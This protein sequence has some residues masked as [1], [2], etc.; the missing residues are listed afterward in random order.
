MSM[1][2]IDKTK[3]DELMQKMK[4]QHQKEEETRKHKQEILEQLK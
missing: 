4:L 1:K 3:R 2:N